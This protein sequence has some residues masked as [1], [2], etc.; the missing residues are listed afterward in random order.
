VDYF[1]GVVMEYL[2]ADRACFVNPEFWIMGKTRPLPSPQFSTAV[3]NVFAKGS[4]RSWQ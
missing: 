2:R 3:G 1:Q 4:G